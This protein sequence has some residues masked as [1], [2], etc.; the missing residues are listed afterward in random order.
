[1]STILT[2]KLTPYTMSMM[3]AAKL[4]P[5]TAF[6]E[7]T[8][9]RLRHLAPEPEPILH[10]AVELTAAELRAILPPAEDGNTA[11]RPRRYITRRKPGK[12]DL[13]PEHYFPVGHTLSLN[14][15]GTTVATATITYV[16]RMKL[17]DRIYIC[18]PMPE[19]PVPPRRHYTPRH[20]TPA[21]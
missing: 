6:F 19:R 14:L 17:N 8:P 18:A 9:H 2:V 13:P 15:G 11:R 1:M 16:R 12:G 4:H 21:P 3:N 20:T 10:P 7:L 5:L